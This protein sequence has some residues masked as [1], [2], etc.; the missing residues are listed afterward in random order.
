MSARKLSDAAVLAI[1][2]APAA[3][4]QEALAAEFGVSTSTISKIQRG[5]HY[6]AGPWP[7]R[8]MGHYCRCPRCR[9]EARYQRARE[10]AASAASGLSERG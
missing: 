4:T 8:P 6:Q 1:R 7:D 2:S 9:S 5:E 10:R 3:H